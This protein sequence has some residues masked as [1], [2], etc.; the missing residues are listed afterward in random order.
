MI[1]KTNEVCK[2]FLRSLDLDGIIRREFVE[3]SRPD[4]RVVKG[5]IRDGVVTGKIVNKHAWIEEDQKFGVSPDVANIVNS[6][7]RV[8]A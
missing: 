2:A 3:G 1:I 6:L 7:I 8:S 4:M 5:W